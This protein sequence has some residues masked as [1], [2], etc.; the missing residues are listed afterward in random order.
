[1]ERSLRNL[2]TNLLEELNVY[3]DDDTGDEYVYDGSKLIKIKIGSQSGK[4]IGDK[5]DKDLQAQEEIERA[6]EAAK[7]G[8]IETADEL[9]ERI[10]KLEN[11]LNDSDIA[12]EI[13]SEANDRVAKEKIK[14]ELAKSERE[15]KEFRNDPIV[16]FEGS[17]N[18]FIKKQLKMVE[19]QTYTR[20]NKKYDGTGII[21][22]GLKRYESE[23]VPIVNVYFDRSGSW[24][25]DK[26][27]IG[28]QALAT[29]EKYIR[30]GKLKVNI[31]YFNTSIFD[32][33]TPQGSGGTFGTPILAD[34]LATKPDNVIV[35]TDADI[36]DCKEYV[37][38]PGVVWYLFK[39]GR[40]DN[41]EQHLQGK[42]ATE[43]YELK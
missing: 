22:K 6:R 11:A 13:T 16:Q 36:T 33:Y 4:S 14:K 37:Q 12:K 21:R 10:K 20:L 26:T 31:K 39:G 25:E 32:T 5:G 9:A 41:L 42:T 1:M 8:V 7:G 23:E 40:S 24:G 2:K 17:L 30:T 28:R 38:V 43:A 19:E 27:K 3:I 29:L 18:H 34:V 35:M 15:L